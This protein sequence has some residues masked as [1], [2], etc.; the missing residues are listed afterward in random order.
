P[1]DI[2]ALSLHDAL[3]IYFRAT[4]PKRRGHHIPQ[5]EVV[6]G[7]VIGEPGD[8]RAGWQSSPPLHARNGEIQCRPNWRDAA[9][10]VV[11]IILLHRRP[12]DDAVDVADIADLAPSTL[13]AC[14]GDSRDRAAFRIG[15]GLD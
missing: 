13:R 5:N 2:S 15:Y 12:I 7:P 1:H 9:R 11:R 3:P 14:P 10:I 8:G 4:R 6:L